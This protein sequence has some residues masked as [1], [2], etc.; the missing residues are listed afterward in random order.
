MYKPTTSQGPQRQP[1]DHRH[2]ILVALCRNHCSLPWVHHKLH[3]TKPVALATTRVCSVPKTSILH[4]PQ[5]RKPTQRI[6]CNKPMGFHEHH[7][8][9]L[10]CMQQKGQQQRLTL[11]SREPPAVPGHH[12][13]NPSWNSGRQCRHHRNRRPSVILLKCS[14]LAS[15]HRGFATHV[16]TL[17]MLTLARQRPM[18]PRPGTPCRGA[19]TIRTPGSH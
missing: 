3:P 14:G 15:P 6:P 17:Q 4:Q 19:R 9:R 8:S 18:A 16:P 10:Q 2:K 12:L 7:N 1:Q 13:E 11:V 5:H